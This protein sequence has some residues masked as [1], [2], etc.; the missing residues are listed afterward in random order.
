VKITC[1]ICNQVFD[2]RGERKHTAKFCS[3]KCKA[4]YQHL[5][6]HG[7]NHPRWTDAIRVKNCG[8]CGQEFRQ[9]KTEAISSFV[10]RKFCSHFCGWLGQTYLSGVKHP[11]WTGGSVKRGYKHDRWAQNVIR[12]DKGICSKCGVSGITMHAHHIKPY[13]SYESL[14]YVLS[15]GI[16]LCAPCHWELHSATIA[17]GKNSGNSLPIHIGA[18][19]EPSLGGNTFEGATTNSRAYGETYGSNANTSLPAE[20]HD[21]V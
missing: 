11:N 13:L 2:A 14:R 10:E 21:I 4:E 19:P 6:I 9:G 18:N 8:Y 12:R 3:I 1:I 7:K 5:Y 17:N 15:N 16:T 20:T